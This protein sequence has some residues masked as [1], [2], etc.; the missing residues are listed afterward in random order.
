MPRVRSIRHA[1]TRL[2]LIRPYVAARDK[3][4]RNG[5]RQTVTGVIPSY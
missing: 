4:L 5:W 3:A 2:A 1:G